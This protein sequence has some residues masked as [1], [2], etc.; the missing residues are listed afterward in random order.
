M[1]KNIGVGTK[2][3]YDSFNQLENNLKPPKQKN[4]MTHLTPKKKKRK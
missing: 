2:E 4:A 1:S 3:K